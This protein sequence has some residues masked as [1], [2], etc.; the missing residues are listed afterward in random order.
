MAKKLGLVLGSGA[1][2]GWAHVGVLRRLEEI[3][4]NADIIAG[5]SVGA[6]VGGAYVLGALEEFEAWARE[7][8]PLS[9]LKSFALSFSRG[10]V[11]NAG[12]AFAAFADFDKR[13][14]ELPTRF[15]AVAADLGTGEEVWITEGSVVEAARASCAIPVIFHAVRREGR[16]LVDGALANPAPV[17]LARAL[18]ADVVISVDLNAV[19]RVLDRFRPSPPP[20]VA[21]AA[22]PANGARDETAPVIAHPVSK[23]IDDTRRLID[24]Q[25]EAARER[26]LSRPQLF[27][28]AYAAADIFQMHLARAHARVAPPDICLEPDMRDALPT[29]FDRADE[30]IAKGRNA[31]AEREE[32]LFSLLA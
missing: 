4:L 21:D 11:V 28:T 20:F 29:A 5:C 9:A 2:R 14:E 15:G 23:L 6:L 27:E 26:S 19:P 12:P 24:Q 30:F 8:K 22:P 16:W 3:G 32:E 1:A 10:G 25:L 7:L 13:I 18:G 31:L 17:S